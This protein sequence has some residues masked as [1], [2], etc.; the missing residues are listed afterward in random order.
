M[1]LKACKECGKEISTT[2]KFCPHC[3]KKKTSRVS[4]LFAIMLILFVI[5][6]LAGIMRSEQQAADT[7]AVESTRRQALTPAQRTQEDAET[8]KEQKLSAANALCYSTLKASLHDPSSAKLD[9]SSGW[10][11]KEQKDGTIRVQPTG[12]AK[13]AFGAYVYGAWDCFVKER[14]K[15]YTVTKLKQ[16]RP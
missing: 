5:G 13:N 15:T 1:A 6:L 8:A 10:Y 7:S 2:A 3:G 16:I 12:R 14:N 11:T 4:I 9:P